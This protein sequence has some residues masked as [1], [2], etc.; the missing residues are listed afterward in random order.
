ML[1]KN[2]IIFFYMYS[3]TFTITGLMLTLCRLRIYIFFKHQS[4]VFFIEQNVGV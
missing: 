1:K 2:L 4:P 3:E